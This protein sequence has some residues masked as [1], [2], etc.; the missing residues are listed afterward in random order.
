MRI[1]V[2]LPTFTPDAGGAAEAAIA[3]EQAGLHG[4]FSFDHLWPLG[5]PARPS[6]SI[7]PMLGA[8][9]AL[10]GRIR[11]GSLV[12]RVGLLPDEVVAASLESLHLSLG[13]RLI[14]GIGVGDQASAPEHE[15]NGIPYL[16]VRP[17]EESLSLLLRRL[18]RRGIECWVGAGTLHAAARSATAR[19][20]SETGVSVN[21]W[22]ITADELTEAGRSCQV[23]VTWA[24]SFPKALDEAT[25]TLRRLR[26]AGASWAV[27]AWPSSLDLVVEAAHGAGVELEEP[28]P[29]AVATS[30]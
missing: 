3:A 30:D 21:F 4:V 17:R 5:H 24:G 14:A 26:E 25:E 18:S 9:A 27:W 1:G 11:V 7:Y 8:V 6:L 15:R 22:Q 16:G 29:E 10:T 28:E 23:P 20:A 2:T 12:A 19:V 13:D